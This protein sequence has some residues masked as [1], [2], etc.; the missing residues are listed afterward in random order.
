MR[1]HKWSEQDYAILERNVLKLGISKGCKKTADQIYVS[2][3]A[4]RAMYQHKFR[5]L[6]KNA[7]KIDHPEKLKE[8]KVVSEPVK[9]GRANGWTEKEK[10]ILKKLINEH[11]FNEGCRKAS[12][13]IDRSYSS[14]VYQAW[15]SGFKSEN[16]KRR[17][18]T[19][20]MEYEIAD[21]L[22]KEIARNP[23]NLQSVFRNAAEKFGVKEQTIENRWYG[24]GTSNKTR[25]KKTYPSTRTVIGPIYS[26][27]GDNATINGKNQDTPNVK[28]TGWILAIFKKFIKRNN[29]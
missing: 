28:K 21:F 23:N 16:P 15:K 10:E 8:A 14:C 20:E 4:A 13:E 9:Q 6:T 17:K 3:R 5:R 27:I 25:V 22:K 2:E 1:N 26:L 19:E 29:K 24:Y 18:V 12:C 7:I 11:G